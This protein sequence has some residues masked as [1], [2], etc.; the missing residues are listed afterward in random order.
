MNKKVTTIYLVRHGQSES[1]KNV[2]S[3]GETYNVDTPLTELGKTQ[4]AETKD[5]LKDIHF[6]AVFSSDLI[7]AKQTAEIIAFER[8]LIVQ[9][10]ELIRERSYL[11]VM[12]SNP[13]KTK[14]EI[15]Q[16]MQEV[17]AS[18]DEKGK[19][20]YKYA[21]DIDSAE[22]AAQRLI[23]YMR[24]ISVAYPGKTVLLVNHGNNIRSFLTYIGYA[25][26]DSLPSGAIKNGAYVVLTCD[27]V[28]FFVKETYGVTISKE[29]SIS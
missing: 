8:K 12:E 17:L 9:T 22:E 2:E 29:M 21:P 25:K 1:N 5:K 23:Q 16:E 28:D 13:H 4:A 3:H 19:H 7:R 11:H 18:L 27:G 14:A 24:E 26:Y 6:D 15:Q 20:A 10:S